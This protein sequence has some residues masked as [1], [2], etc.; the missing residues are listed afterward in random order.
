MITNIVGAAFAAIFPLLVW[1]L[2]APSASMMTPSEAHA[3]STPHGWFM[4]VVGLAMVIGIL[5]GHIHGSL[6]QESKGPSIASLIGRTFQEPSL[7]RSL[8]AA[9]LVFGGIYSTTMQTADPVVALI[10]AFQ[11]GFFCETLVKKPAATKK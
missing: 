4:L 9:P 1:W 3:N 7:Y 10:F 8:L 5:F 11:N 6:K 2:I